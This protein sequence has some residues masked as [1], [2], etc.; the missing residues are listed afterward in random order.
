MRRQGFYVLNYFNVCEYGAKMLDRPVPL[1]EAAKD[2]D[3]WQKPLEFLKVRLPNACLQ[4]PVR[5]GNYGWLVDVGDPGYQ[6]HILEQA[7]RH[8]EKLPDT[9]GICIDRMDW[10]RFYNLHADDGVSWVDGRP[11]RSLFQSWLRCT[12]SWAR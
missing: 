2:P 9:S 12:P 3:L 5:V 8:I 4:P 1:Q 10:L 6:Q 7:K 11:A